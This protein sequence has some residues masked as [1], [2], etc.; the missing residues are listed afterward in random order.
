M[1][2]GLPAKDWRFFIR[3]RN[4]PTY[5]FRSVCH[6]SHKPFT[7]LPAISY[8]LKMSLRGSFQ[9]RGIRSYIPSSRLFLSCSLLG[10]NC[11]RRSPV[12]TEIRYCGIDHNSSC[13]LRTLDLYSR[14]VKREALTGGPN[15]PLRSVLHHQ[16]RPNS[17]TSGACTII[18]PHSWKMS[19]FSLPKILKFL[20]L[21]KQPFG[22]KNGPAEAGPLQG[23][24][25]VREENCGV[26]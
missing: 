8:I 12:T 16:C 18:L 24:S 5:G 26:P 9:N 25:S 20:P 1:Q 19:S 17:P 3:K 2:G 23:I 4:G 10:Q 11:N 22:K 13:S 15:T 21:T 14:R 7:T 6:V